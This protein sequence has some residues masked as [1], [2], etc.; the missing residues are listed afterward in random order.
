MTIE[1]HNF[2]QGTNEWFAARRGIPTA[3]NFADIISRGRGGSTSKMRRTYMLKLLGE[4]IT[5]GLQQ[6]FTNAHTARGH[7]HEDLAR[8]AYMWQTDNHVE[9]VG[10]IVDYELGAGCSPDGLVDDNGSVE[11]KSKLRCQGSTKR[12]SR[13]LCWSPGAIGATS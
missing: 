8:E 9:Q 11:I 10:F 4:R 12:K 6:N 5:G 1:I 13:A 3:S 7:E 2:E